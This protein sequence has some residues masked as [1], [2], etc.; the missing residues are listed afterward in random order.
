MQG[1]PLPGAQWLTG[2]MAARLIDD[3]LPLLEAVSHY[4][5]VNAAA[6]VLGRN[7]SGISRQLQRLSADL[8]TPL[9]RRRGRQ[10]E[11]TDAA[12]ALVREAPHLHAAEERARSALFDAADPQVGQVRIAAH[13]FAVSAIAVPALA[14]WQEQHP[15]STWLLREAEPANAQRLLVSREA[16]LVVMP[17][18]P[19]TPPTD[20]PRFTVRRLVVE[21]VDL[22]I[23]QDHP[24]AAEHGDIDLV[25]VSDE[26][27]VLGSPGQGSRQEILEHC[28]KAGFTPSEGHHAQDWTAVSSLVAAGLGVSFMPRMAPTH[29]GVVRVPLSGPS[30]PVRTVLMVMRRGSEGWSLLTETMEALV[31]RAAEEVRRPL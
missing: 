31:S 22:I 27:W 28:A 26:R 4:G 25:E 9:L 11:L 17:A 30:A 14:A 21:P 20:H 8:G 1:I 18:G 23:S 3:A 13:V 10:V 6:D 12:Q 19:H 29:P 2:A 7:A 16:D 24:L 5:G 15:Q